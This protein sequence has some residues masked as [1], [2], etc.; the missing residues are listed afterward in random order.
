MCAVCL[1]TRKQTRYP[2]NFLAYAREIILL[3]IEWVPSMSLVSLSYNAFME[4]AGMSRDVE[5]K[6]D[7]VSDFPRVCEHT[8]QETERGK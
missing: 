8:E 4:C 3:P 2:E 6:T 5:S 1:T 7:A